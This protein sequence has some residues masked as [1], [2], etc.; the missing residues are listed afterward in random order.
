MPIVKDVDLK[1]VDVSRRDTPNKRDT[2]VQVAQYKK[3]VDVAPQC[4]RGQARR[5]AVLPNVN[6]ARM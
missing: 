2:S 5:K 4:S 6:V 3:E 1:D